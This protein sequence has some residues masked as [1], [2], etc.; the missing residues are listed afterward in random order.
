M[1]AAPTAPPGDTVGGAAIARLGLR[2]ATL[3]SCSR[4]HPADQSRLAGVDPEGPRCCRAGRLFVSSLTVA[5]TVCALCIGTTTA[6]ITSELTS[7]AAVIAA[8]PPSSRP[9]WLP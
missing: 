8:L 2:A 5:V 1:T 6:W 9:T 4:R 3:R 7:R